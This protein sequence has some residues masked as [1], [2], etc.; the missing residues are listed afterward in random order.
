MIQQTDKPL[1]SGT[2][3]AAWK[4]HPQLLADSI[5]VTELPICAVRLLDDA[6]F[7]WIMLIPRIAG[8]TQWLDMP[9]DIAH[10]V[11]D[12]VHEAQHVLQQIFNPI[13]I[14]FA[15]IGNRVDQLHIHCVARFS[16]DAAWP[17]VV[18]GHGTRR[19]YKP[20]DRLTR[21][22]AIAAGLKIHS[23]RNSPH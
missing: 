19:N 23:R 7:P 16:N 8:L 6:R 14:N 10:Q 22:N 15:T 17:D 21:A 18:W 1:A 11:L 12:E 3:D 5:P 4:L 2:S 13:R 20:L 9:Q